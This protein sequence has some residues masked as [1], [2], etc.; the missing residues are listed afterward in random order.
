M[1]R[2]L[3]GVLLFLL[4]QTNVHSALLVPVPGNWRSRRRRMSSLSAQIW[5]SMASV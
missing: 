2:I 3:L 5:P 1:K 4:A